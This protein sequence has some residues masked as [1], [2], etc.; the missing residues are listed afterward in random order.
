MSKYPSSPHRCSAFTL[1]E[2]LVVIAIIAILIGM[3]LPAVQ[4]VREAAARAQCGNNLKQ[5]GL[6]LAN[7]HD[8]MGVFPPGQGGNP[9]Q[10]SNASDQFRL[11]A[12]YYL[13][14]F[15][16]QGNLY[17]LIN[18][19]ATYGSTTYSTTNNN[20]P[21]D[22][23]D[24]NFVPYGY[25]Y[26]IKLLHCPADV[27]QYDNRGGLTGKL[28][29]SNYAVCWGDTITDTQLGTTWT[30]SKKRGMFGYLSSLNYPGI[31]DGS[32]N[33]IAMSEHAFYRSSTSML[34]N[35]SDNDTTAAS[36]PAA[37][38]ATANLATGQYNTGVTVDGYHPGSRAFD[39]MAFFTGFN[40][41]LP[42]N[43]PS[44]EDSGSN[45]YGIF[46]AS[47]RHLN[48]I[49]VLFADGSIHFISQTINTGNMGAA[50]VSSGPSPYGVWG[51]LGTISGGETITDY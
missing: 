47:S 15:I 28:A 5:L 13:T 32:S 2:L 8:T 36:N 4:K 39:G 21:P 19:P 48:G 35:V 30:S 51:A 33:T 50:Q 10:P 24:Q 1:I 38:L 7:Y 31:V 16:E 18:T 25:A 49:N 17:N 23:W 46:S 20:L 40:T 42:P 44:C 11:S 6:A 22:P 34:G 27:P 3:L 29:S 37:C 12:F 41:V 45:S 9:G 26:Q 43:S 14:Q